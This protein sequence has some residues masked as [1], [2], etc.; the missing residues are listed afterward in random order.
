MNKKCKYIMYINKFLPIIEENIVAIF[1]SEKV[2][3]T[4]TLFLDKGKFIRAKMC[5]FAALL[6][7]GNISEDDIY[8]ASIIETIH[9]ISLIHDDV[10]DNNTLR[11]FQNTLNKE[12]SNSYSVLM[13]DL[14]LL[15]LLSKIKDEYKQKVID[16]IKKMITGELLQ[17]K[18][19][20]LDYSDILEKYYEIISLKTGFLVSKA[21]DYNDTLEHIGME[22]G[23]CYQILDDINDYNHDLEDKLPYNDFRSR[24]LTLP[25]I[26]SLDDKR[27]DE[28]YKYFINNEK[29]N[30]DF[31]IEKYVKKGIQESRIILNNRIK[32]LLDFIKKNYDNDYGNDFINYIID[33]FHYAT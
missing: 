12:K 3:I 27:D 14:C 22:F 23:I 1:K 28:V 33:I 15:T 6:D 30:E 19:I 16:I 29:W 20:S 21:C 13:G 9:R 4:Q 31:D 10:I 5:L 18:Y 7:H 24:I 17:R 11:H 32:K 8:K 2:D 26:L 25:M